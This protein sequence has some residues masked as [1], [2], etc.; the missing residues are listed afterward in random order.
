MIRIRTIKNWQ[1]LAA[2]F[3]L[4]AS[5]SAF[6]AI[7]ISSNIGLSIVVTTDDNCTTGGRYCVWDFGDS[8][9]FVG[10]TAYHTYAEIGTRYI[11]TRT[12]H[13]QILKKLLLDNTR[14]GAERA[15]G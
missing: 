13:L 7:K 3:L 8:H 15:H 4:F 1:L 12:A 5:T 10:T 2:V 6:S 11:N 14:P 9:G